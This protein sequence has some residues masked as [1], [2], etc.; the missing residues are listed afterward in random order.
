[1]IIFILLFPIMSGHINILMSWRV[2]MKIRKNVKSSLNIKCSMYNF[3]VCT[4]CLKRTC[5]CC[6]VVVF[7]FEWT[8]CIKAH[9]ITSLFIHLF[10]VFLY[11]FLLYDTY[12]RTLFPS[13]SLPT[14]NIT[15][16]KIAF[17][18]TYFFTVAL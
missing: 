15:T 1:M 4:R 5:G 9:H 8:H 2:W 11:T 7:Y 10:N 17:V 12:A 14:L 3:Y 18:G 13:S 16:T 6:L